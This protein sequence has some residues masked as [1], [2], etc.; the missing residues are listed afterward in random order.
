MS[1]ASAY[2]GTA[3]MF[4]RAGFTRSSPTTSKAQGGRPRI[5]VRRER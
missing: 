2:T 3:G 5:V 1:S 4:E